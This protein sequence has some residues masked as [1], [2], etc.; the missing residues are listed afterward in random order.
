[1][2]KNKVRQI[3]LCLSLTQR[4]LAEKA[5]TSQQ[6]IQ[7]IESGKIATNLSLAR[8]IST[9]LGKPLEVVFP[10]AAKALKQLH[11]EVEKT[12]YLS[13]ERLAAV[14]KAG[15]EADV[16][17]WFLKVLLRGRDEPFIFNISPS[18]K[19]RL[20][21]AMQREGDLT[22]FVAFDTEKN[23]VALNLHE[24]TFHQF[25]FEGPMVEFVSSEEDGASNREDQDERVRLIFVDG[26][27]IELSVEQDEPDDDDDVGQLGHILSM[28]EMGVPEEN[29]RYRITDV[30]GEDA[31][32]RAGSLSLIQVPLWALREIEDSS[33]EEDELAE[34]R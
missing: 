21:V 33:E 31:F 6:Q 17:T 5:G 8:S 1:M 2:S 9:V 26:R 11:E 20:Y 22:A 32:I 29:E 18:E 14:E 34:T 24:V 23:C 15:I 30:D 10:E 19:R 28:L 13:D 7:R 12:R 27:E 25:L 3:R 16:K 4:E